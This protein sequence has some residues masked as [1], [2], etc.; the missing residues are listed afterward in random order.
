MNVKKTTNCARGSPPIPGHTIPINFSLLLLLNQP[1]AGDTPQIFLSLDN[2]DNCPTHM[3]HGMHAHVRASSQVQVGHGCGCCSGCR[4][5]DAAAVGGHVGGAAVRAA[6]LLLAAAIRL[7]LLLLRG[8]APGRSEGRRRRQTRRVQ[9]E[10]LQ[11]E[12]LVAISRV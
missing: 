12:V 11:I 7:L 5:R 8:R 10:L 9:Q 3:M 6:L 1:K 4:G 2:L